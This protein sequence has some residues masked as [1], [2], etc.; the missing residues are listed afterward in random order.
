MY[1]LLTFASG[2]GEA[3]ISHA[4]HSNMGSFFARL[5][6]GG[7]ERESAPGPSRVSEQ[8]KAILV[9]NKRMYG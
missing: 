5:R 4:Y 8:D 9:R 3:Y 1:L 6:G 2:W 7:A